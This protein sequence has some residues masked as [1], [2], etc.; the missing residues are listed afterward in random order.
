MIFTKVRL[1]VTLALAATF[2][3]VFA[4]SG[5]TQTTAQISPQAAT[6]S[7]I[8][9][10]D[11][12]MQAILDS[13]T[14][15]KPKPI[16]TLSAAE[17]RRQPTFA[18]AVKNLLQKR[19]TSTAPEP[20]GKIENRLIDGANGK[21][22]ARIYTPTGNGTFP[23]IVYYHG[24]GWVFATIDT[25]DS[26]ARALTN[27]A[28]AIVVSVEYRKGPEHKFPAAHNDAFAAYRWVLANARSFNGDP[29]KVAVAGESAGGNLAVNVAIAARD[30]KIQLPAHIVSVYPVA[31]NDLNSPSMIE[32]AKAK[33]LNRAMLPWFL[34]K[35]LKNQAESSNPRISLVKANLRGLPATT[36]IA[37]DI[38]PL[39]SEGMLLSERLQA[40]GVQVDYK[41]YQGVTHEFFGTG[42]VND[43]AKEAVAQAAKGLRQ[44][45]GN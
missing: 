41:N 26:S 16:E 14:S 17:A 30:Q 28:E 11:P 8:A 18:D 33:P 24:G 43:K 13:F 29:T 42:A 3:L 1:I 35:Y 9:R 34:D 20:V 21:I 2:T 22:A 7:A 27:A 4:L 25:Y 40:A 38:D 6:K 12:Q 5:F 37:A 32:N 39:R 23:V 31:N 45:F 15:L 36:L 10:P 44:A 19:G